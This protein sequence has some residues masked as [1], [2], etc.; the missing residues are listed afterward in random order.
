M[1]AED[2]SVMRNP[3][4]GNVKHKGPSIGTATNLWNNGTVERVSDLDLTFYEEALEELK[5]KS[6]CWST[7]KM[8]GVCIPH[9]DGPNQNVAVF[10]AGHDD[11]CVQVFNLSSHEFDGLPWGINVQF[12][13]SLINKTILVNCGSDSNGQL[14]IEDLGNFLDPWGNGGLK[15]NS[16]MTASILWN[17][18]NATQVDLGTGSDF[19]EF[20]GSILIPNGNLDFQI[21]GHS[22]VAIVGG[23]LIQ[24]FQ[25][26]EFHNY[27]FDPDAHPNCQLPLPPFC[28]E[29]TPA[30]TKKPTHHPTSVPTPYNPDAH[31]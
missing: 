28:P 12:H 26:S 31:P 23:D 15:F 18:Y 25:G 16:G 10:K 2:V 20:Q 11:D 30:P 29:P 7:L 8:N 5:V 4:R 21:P 3:N 13:K 27:P 24:E 14:Q 17:F 1:N 9:F 19:G 22:G 6:A